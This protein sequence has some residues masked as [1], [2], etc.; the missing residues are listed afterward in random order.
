[1]DEKVAFY[2]RHRD[3]IEEWAKLR[4]LA[5]LELH[6]ALLAELILLRDEI[7]TDLHIGEYPRA[8][9]P[10]GVSGRSEVWLCWSASQLFMYTAGH[11]NYPY[12]GLIVQGEK[13]GDR[14]FDAVRTAAQPIAIVHRM[15]R[16]EPAWPWW[17][18]MRP[19]KSTEDI[20]DYGHEIVQEFHSIWHDL[21]GIV[22]ETIQR[23]SA[24]E[25]P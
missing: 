13:K 1:M 3:Q 16:S 10:I 5:A 14:V 24:S 25:Q 18:P 23:V 11:R 15:T 12:V 19:M 21:K 4:D 6:D 7:G 2:I 22:D 20:G 17:G 9:L 8:A